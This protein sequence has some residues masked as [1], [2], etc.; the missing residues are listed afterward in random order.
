M[1][2]HATAERTIRRA[3]A[4]AVVVAA[5]CVLAG[6]MSQAPSAPSSS[7]PWPAAAPLPR[8]RVVWML[9]RAALAEL[10]ADPAIRAGLDGSPVYEILQPG[11]EPLAGFDA[12][13]T[14]TFPSLVALSHAVTGGRLPAGTRAVLYD[15]EAWSFTPAAEQRDPVQAATR[16]AGLARAHGLQLIVAPALNLTTVLAR[17]S[18]APR[19]QQ[20]L[21][22]QLA[23]KMAKVA[24]VIE[25]QA[26]SLERDSTTYATFVREAAA[27]AHAANPGVTVLA[28]LS[29]NPPGALVAS[30]QLVAAIEASRASVDGYWLNIPDRGPRCPTCNQKRPDVGID[31]LRAVL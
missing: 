3:R 21:D 5:A 19:W 26:Q 31:A 30:D 7:R 4:A 16:A 6:C 15:P 25:L 10:I 27:Q 29:T 23:A 14:V 12:A 20:F 18:A 8:G 9:T 24:D 28:G 17:G 2:R 1:T 13:V 11:Q 22:L